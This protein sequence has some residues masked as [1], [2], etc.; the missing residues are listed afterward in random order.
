MGSFTILSRGWRCFT[1]KK[2]RNH[3][4][5]LTY[6]DAHLEYVLFGS[7]N[8]FPSKMANFPCLLFIE[9]IFKIFFLDLL[10]V[11][12]NFKH[13]LNINGC[14]TWI[15]CRRFKCSLVSIASNDHEK[16]WA[17]VPLIILLQQH[18]LVA[19]HS[20]LFSPIEPGS[21]LLSRLTSF[22]AT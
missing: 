18:L 20:W 10:R 14:K 16:Y 17:L 5:N 13:R 21:V 1:Q 6:T 4:F 11:Q 2:F 9:L 22:P 8:N 3:L 15:I 19:L 7:L 12:I